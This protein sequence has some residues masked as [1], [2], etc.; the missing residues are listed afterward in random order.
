LNILLCVFL[1][2]WL[3]DFIGCLN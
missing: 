2:H 3:W 1:G